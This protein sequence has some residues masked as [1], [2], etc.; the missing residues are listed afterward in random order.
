MVLQTDETIECDFR[1]FVPAEGIA[2]YNTRI[3]F[4][5]VVTEETL[6]EM[7]GDLAQSVGLLPKAARFDAIGYGCTSGSAVIGEDRIA[8]IVTSVAP[9]ASVTNPLTA[10]K[11]AL[12]A[13]GA[14][15][16]AM[17]T[18]YMPAVSEALVRRF[19][20]GGIETVAL[21]SFELLEDAAVARV[22]PDSILDAVVATGQSNDCDAVFASCT[23]LRTAGIITEAERR[24]GKP[25]VT[26]N[27]AL[28]WH[29]L[30]LADIPRG[31]ESLG[32]LARV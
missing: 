13:L 23:S 14:R 25:V 1:A 7:E 2:F 30:R 32:R 28:A 17:V 20:E 6:A 3:P 5:P 29:M 19:A 31:P 18:P 11:S 21:A 12:A 24:L 9:N 15:R 22:T 10:A 27:Q 26:S 4:A 16:I 8:E